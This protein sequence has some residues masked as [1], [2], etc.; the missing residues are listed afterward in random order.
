MAAVG[1]NPPRTAAV[2]PARPNTTQ[3]RVLSDDVEAGQGLLRCTG[4]NHLEMSRG[5]SN[6]ILNSVHDDVEMTSRPRSVQPTGGRPRS[7]Q[8]PVWALGPHW[9][10][11]G[12][13]Q[14]GWVLLP[15]RAFLGFTF[16][17]AGLQKLA[18][19]DFFNAG[20]PG[21]VQHQMSMLAATSP[22]GPLVD[23]SLH[24]GPLVGILIAVGELA[25]GVGTLL[26]LRARWAAA[27]GAVLALTFFLTVSWNTSPY[28]Y[29]ADIIFLFAWTPFITMGAGGV[30]STDA[31]LAARTDAHARRGVPL[32][33]AQPRRLVLIT[34]LATVTLAALT[35]AVGRLVG[36]TP[37]GA[38]A[39]PSSS[40]NQG[41]VP[42]AA[43]SPKPANP[44]PSQSPSGP[45]P[46]RARIASVSSLPAG[47]AAAFTDPASGG[48]AW[49]FCRANEEYSAHSAVCT[50][51]GCTVDFDPSA[52]ELVCPCHG[53]DLQ[54][55]HRSSPVRAAP[56]TTAGDP[57]IHRRG[58]DLCGLA[59]GAGSQILH[60]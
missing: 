27:A 20:S 33:R 12:L 38:A 21:S 60:M 42:N 41:G 56:G 5:G 15:L 58:P 16:C 36:G 2:A 59:V 14:P 11:Q 34:G 18:N 32:D 37:D 17:Y 57:G 49:V 51:A 22:I 46:S 48:P 9:A 54:R 10:A 13:R 19:P 40:G 24:G 23:L 4:F 44:Q 50:H 53:G 47:R 3:E 8:A 7:S 35:A 25:I 55:S 43:A 29:G 31:W 26:G 52:R 28:Y 39:A 1:A 6:D 45:A 30:L